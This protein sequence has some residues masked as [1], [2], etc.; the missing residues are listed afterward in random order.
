MRIKHALLF[1][2]LIPPF[3]MSQSVGY[4]DAD[5]PSEAVGMMRLSIETAEI[6]RDRCI[7]HDP[8]LQEGIDTD[9]LKW[10]TAERSVL[11]KATYYWNVMSEKEP[12][13]AEMLKQAER[14]VDANLK[15]FSDMP[16]AAS[17]K[18]IRQYCV[19]HF[20]DLAS[21]VWR[22]RT[23]RAYEYMDKAP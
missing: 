21:G 12:Q 17:Q 19:Q 2:L 14:V 6:L 22:A 9:L 11:E 4:S 13:L 18:V 15:V 7:Q 1:L 8:T 20:S 16:G 5:T 23:P 3:G 10:K